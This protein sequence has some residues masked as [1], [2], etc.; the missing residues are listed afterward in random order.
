MNKYL[1]RTLIGAVGG[2]I[3]AYVAT[4]LFGSSLADVPNYVPYVVAVLVGVGIANLPAVL[5]GSAPS[6]NLVT[7]DKGRNDKGGRTSTVAAQPKPAPVTLAKKF[8]SDEGGSKVSYTTENQGDGSVKVTVTTRGLTGREFKG[9]GGVR[10]R[11]EKVGG[12]KW[13]KPTNVTAQAKRG[14]ATKKGGKP[15]AVV[16]TV[17]DEPT[18]RVLTGTIAAGNQSK[19][20]ADLKSVLGASSN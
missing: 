8:E 17:S 16:T 20:L 3:V 2:A 9:P 12:I 7:S 4:V 19:V 10:T 15:T 14:G 11:L 6:A 18:T 1:T 13:D 5:G